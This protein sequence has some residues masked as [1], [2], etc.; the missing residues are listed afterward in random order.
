MQKKN[1]EKS[2]LSAALLGS[3][4]AFNVVSVYLFGRLDLTRDDQFTLSRATET[5]L[6]EL[7]EPVTVR[8][9][10]TA[11]LPPPYGSNARYV[12]D[13]LDEYFAASG[14]NFRYEFVD[15]AAEESDADKELKKD[16]KQD[17]FGR[18]VREA[19][20]VEKELQT[21]GIPPVQV[22][23]NEGDKLEVKRAYMGLAIHYGDKKDVIPV[24][25]DTN[26]LEYD[27]TTLIRKMT[28]EKTPKIAFVTGHGGVDAQKDMSRVHQLIGQL[29]EVTSVDLSTSEMPADIDAVIV[30]GP[31][32][33]FSDDEKRKLDQFVMSGKGAAF[34]LDSVQPDLQTLEA[35]DASHGLGDLLK[36]YGVELMPGLVLDAE[37]ATINITQQRGFMRIAQP[38]KYPFMPQPKGLDASHPLTRGLQAVALPF[39]SPV[40]VAFAEQDGVRADVLVKSS[41]N[42]WIQEPPYNLDPLQRWTPD[43]V[44]DAG[45]KS[46]LV[47]V[48]G[49]L[50]SF[51]GEGTAQNGRVLVAGG[52]AFL[53][54]QFMSQTNQAL[55]LNL[56]D[57]LVLDEALLSMRAR[58]LAAAPL[59]ELSD[60]TRGM[61][62]YINIVG[63]PFAFIAFGLVRW[64]VREKRRRDVS[65]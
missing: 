54:D 57:W 19:T 63:L 35:K 36:A 53:T 46:L 1:L 10:F 25:Q 42:S 65:L 20:S 52:S 43:L 16:V 49:A 30:A 48:S 12:R 58:G 37:C 27:L 24:V 44:K 13:L 26:G 34:L 7:K 50:K 2:T 5:V 29:Y 4:V 14:G 40:N 9:Y 33:P 3:L 6:S 21:L 31:A 23:V 38:V 45:T 56:I 41:S 11:D 32:T 8:A 60:G 47:T 28:R 59:A 55:A 62:K 22:R 18:A 39:I 17:I 15:P 51:S 64:R 61:V